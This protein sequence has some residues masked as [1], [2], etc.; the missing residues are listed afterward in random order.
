M[1]NFIGFF[2]LFSI[3]IIFGL[4]LKGIF[5]LIIRNIKSNYFKK[6]STIILLALI[7]SNSFDPMNCDDWGRGLN[8][9]FIEDD[10]TKLI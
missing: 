1:F 2:S 5:S 3:I 6:F 4:I 10:I 8:N 7:Y 9:T